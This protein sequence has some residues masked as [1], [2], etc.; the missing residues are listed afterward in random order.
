MPAQARVWGKSILPNVAAFPKLLKK[1]KAL[2]NYSR[3]VITTALGL[4]LAL[5]QSRV[6][7]Q[8]TSSKLKWL[9]GPANAQLKDIAQIQVPAGFG[10]LDGKSTRRLL[11]T[12]GEPT[13]GRE[14]GMIETTNEDWSVF[15][16]FNDIGYVKDDEKDKLNADKL[17]DSYKRGTAEQNKVRER[18][19]RPPLEIVG[20]EVP[21]RYDETTHNLEWAIRATSAGQQILNYNTRLLG[22]KGVMEVVLIVEPDK[23]NEIM[24]Q[25][26]S[27]LSSY[28]FNTGQTYAEYRQGD[29]IAKYGLAALVLGGAAVGAAKL[30][31]LA[32]VAVLFKKAWKLIVVAFAAVATFLKNL[33]AK[34]FG[35]KRQDQPTTT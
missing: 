22:R 10:F 5:G 25:Y 34:I 29:K 35:R 15:F 23:L 31:L 11:E 30:G 9:K 26:R 14:L 32:W 4:T 18:N 3:T 21:P 17:L 6:A 1:G 33:F 12:A 2:M 7:A 8:D 13:S 28:S 16:D 24:P 20:W 19:G 27:L